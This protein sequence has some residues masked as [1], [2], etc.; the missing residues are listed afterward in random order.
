MLRT[1]FPRCAS[2]T[3]SRPLF[4]A[5][6][7]GYFQAGAAELHVFARTPSSTTPEYVDVEVSD[8]AT[9]AGLKKAIIAEL[10]LDTTAN[11]V[12]LLLEVEGGHFKPLD[13]RKK[14]GE[15][16]VKE[17]SSVTLEELTSQAPPRLAPFSAATIALGSDATLDRNLLDAL[18]SFEPQA[19]SRRIGVLN[20]L[21]KARL[22]SLPQ[23]AWDWDA[24]PLFD[25][26]AHG[27]LLEFLVG[28][29]DA[30][31]G[32]G[33]KGL[34]GVACR[35]LVGSRGIGKTAMMR[36]FATVCASAFPGIVPLYVSA[37]GID[38][39]LN[40]FHGAQLGDLMCEAV[41]ARGVGVPSLHDLDSALHK[42]GLRM[43][44][45]LDEVDDLYRVRGATA[46]ATH[47]SQT[48]GHLAILGGQKTGMYG[49]LL[50]GSSSSTYSLV[51]GQT[52]HLGHKFP[53]VT[54]GVPNLN[55]TKY[56]RMQ[57]HSAS[58]AASPEVARMLAALA[59]LSTLPLDCMPL[60]R[61]LT[62]FVGA[63]PRA[64]SL[65]MTPAR[66]S[67][68]RAAACHHHLA[69]A[70]PAASLP[71]DLASPGAP[72]LFQ[73]LLARLRA[74]N[75]KLC[76]LTRNADGGVNFVAIMDPSNHWE[77]AVVP[78]QWA[79]VE[80]VWGECTRSLGQPQ[81]AT[82]SGLLRRLVDDIT[83]AH[84]L[85]QRQ[86]SS[87]GMELWPVT[88]AQ[89][90]S[91]GSVPTDWME[92]ASLRLEPLTK[93]AKLATDVYTVGQAAG[94]VATLLLKM[95]GSPYP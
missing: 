52:G 79:E 27:T 60:A 34:N 24:L 94:N 57:L 16:G 5:F 68:Q 71:S 35:T 70:A 65:A 41:R 30:L 77:G 55:S 17:G 21:V 58:C 22:S 89:V 3:L 80:D 74:S 66:G 1:F 78:L 20:Q 93:L 45:L 9:V 61:L 4:T 11:R 37:E 85:H 48:L 47:V 82:D 15:E 14:L 13:A 62:F 51:C 87:G 59:G 76:A 38:N 33:F 19:A 63:S 53:L 18:T 90:V 36:A 69:L 67:K 42:N 44:V 56:V 39:V 2:F 75:A 91:A 83:D 29:T 73:A 28:H 26:E 81:A 46:T 92:Q 6:L 54:Q 84:L 31:A 43:L 32:G 86:G 23:A 88:V 40:P 8:G 95:G 25:T 50:C 64:V 10:Q 49:V 12:R 72:P 7:P